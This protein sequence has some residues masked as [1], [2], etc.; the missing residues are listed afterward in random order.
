VLP[1][2]SATTVKD[3]AK[4]PTTGVANFSEELLLVLLELKL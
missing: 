2:S 3:K 4:N 1:H